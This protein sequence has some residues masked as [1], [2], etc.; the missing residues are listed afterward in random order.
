MTEAHPGARPLAGISRRR[1]LVTLRDEYV[2][3]RF[4]LA[5]EVLLV[6]LAE[7]GEELTRR[8]VVLQEAS[9]ESLCQFVISNGIDELICGAIEEEFHQYLTWKKVRVLDSVVAEWETALAAHREGSL[10][11]GDVLLERAGDAGPEG[12]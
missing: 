4:D 11:E 2:S 3:P 5:T 9:A 6:D 1:V 12:E 7:D 10:S 8:L